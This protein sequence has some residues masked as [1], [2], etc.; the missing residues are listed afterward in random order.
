M[1]FILL[2]F[3]HRRSTTVKQGSEIRTNQKPP[4]TSQFHNTDAG[5]IVG[6]NISRIAD[7]NVLKGRR[8]GKWWRTRRG[9]VSNDSLGILRIIGD[10]I[11]QLI[12]TTSYFPL[13]ATHPL[14]YFVYSGTLAVY[15]YE[16][17]EEIR[18]FEDGAYYGEL[19][20]FEQPEI[21][22]LTVAIETTEVYFLEVEDF[23]RIMKN[24]PELFERAKNIAIVSLID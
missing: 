8:C 3:F 21:T 13:C 16:T 14:R 15:H 23:L 6:S 5:R 1:T 9:N 4:Q 12:A 2:F 22:N 20:L 7:R 24:Y 11:R 18:H 10:G 17:G 19:S